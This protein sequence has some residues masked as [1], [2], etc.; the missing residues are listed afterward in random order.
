MRSD[1]GFLECITGALG[2]SF[3]VVNVRPGLLRTVHWYAKNLA[4]SL[5]QVFNSSVDNGPVFNSLMK[6]S[7]DRV[8]VSPNLLAGVWWSV[9]VGLP[10]LT[11]SCVAPP[12]DPSRMAIF[13]S[14]VVP[15]SVFFTMFWFP[16][17]LAVGFVLA[18][19]RGPDEMLT[20]FHENV[21]D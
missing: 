15:V 17:T 20:V 3:A 13:G 19:P 2:N 12:T 11:G 5:S 10:W 21:A 7:S 18:V 9:L 14:T 4:R 1:G 16:V 6:A 8:S